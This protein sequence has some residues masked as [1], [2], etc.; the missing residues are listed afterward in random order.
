MAR[1]PSPFRS[2][3]RTA[4]DAL[5]AA[6]RIAFGPVVFQVVR[7]LRELGVLA[8]LE[9]ASRRGATLGRLAEETGVPRSS[10][11]VL[12]ESALTVDVVCQRAADGE[13]ERYALTKIGWLLLHDPMTRANVDFVHDVCF[14]ALYHLEEASRSERPAGLAEIGPGATV[15]EALATLPPKVRASWLAFDHFYS[16][17]AFEAAARIVAGSA[18]ARL[19]DVGANTGKFALR[20]LVTMPRARL[21]LV[22][23]PGQL[24][25]ARRALGEA[26]TAGA[27]PPL[28]RVEL[29]PL[30]VL[31][32][33]A[34]FPGPVDAVWMSQ[35]LE[36][37]AEDD[38]V[39]ILRRARAAL[40]TGGAVW[41]LGSYWDRQASPLAAFCIA[42][43]SPY[44]T[45]VA[46][47]TSRMYR[48]SDVERL[49]A[50]AGLRVADSVD[51]LGI[52]HTLVRLVPHEP[53]RAS[54]P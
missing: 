25:M 50:C 2:P 40:A 38:V 54:S 20:C 9:R 34:R 30:D 14:R 36:C 17:S 27:E 39:S 47:G 37:F 7:A 19:L 24:A 6:Q 32:R 43:T 12:V 48:F 52:A 21:T 41:I 23:L 3:R 22:D 28:A 29:V 33:H 46:T 18:P 5:D 13:D 51:G 49:A 35:F 53:A 11:A 44:F 26:A 4:L 45:A 15:Y 16:D 31:D 8:S 42:N 1:K 10:I